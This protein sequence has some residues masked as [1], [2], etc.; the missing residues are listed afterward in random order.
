MGG[1]RRRGEATENITIRLS[2]ELYRRIEAMAQ[3]ERRSRTAQIE[4]LL[5]RA[6][7]SEPTPAP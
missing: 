6:L 2:R 3:Q 1:R 5:E 4:V 7:R